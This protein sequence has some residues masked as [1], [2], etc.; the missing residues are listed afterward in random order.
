MKLFLIYVRDEDYY[1]LLP[2]KLSRKRSDD[3]V[4]VMAFPPLGIQTLAPAI[5]MQGHDVRMFDTCHPQMKE[6]DIAK[7]AKEE[8]PDIIALSFLST[9]SYP[10]CQSMA[11]FLKEDSPGIPIIIGGPFAT[12]N[13]IQILKDTPSID[14]VGIGEGEELIPDFLANIDDPGQVRGLVWRSDGEIIKNA[15]R[16]LLDDLDKYPYPDRQSLPIEYI[17]SMPLDVPAVLSLD[18]FCTMQT[19]RGCPFHC[20]YCDIPQIAQGKW[21][22]RSPEHV[23]GE[24]QELNDQGYRSIYLTDDH[25]LMKRK[26]IEAICNG[27]IDL[28]L[29]FHWGCE[30]RVDALAIDMLPL[31]KKANCN[32]LAFGVEAGTQKVLDRLNKNQTLEQIE[33]AIKEAK[34]IGIETVHGFFLIGSPD[35]TEEDIKESFRFAAKLNLDTF[36]FNRL[37]AYRGT[38]LWKEYV[39]RGIIDDELDWNKWFKCSDIDPT[40]LPSHVVNNARK[41]G[42]LILF[43]YLLRHRPIATFRLLRKFGRYMTTADIFKLLYSPFK[44]RTLTKLPDLPE[45]MLA[46]GLTEPIREA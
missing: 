24:M 44:K 30:G 8:A 18:R 16:P 15:A 13:A 17:E 21:R 43:G 33:N 10:A 25:F 37:C 35:E 1:N 32:F 11:K 29:G 3:R 22:Q 27:I 7:A 5:R 39:D 46:Q 26:R 23:L 2:D 19:T 31:M 20:I 34:R 45:K 38:P 9:T 28:K 4:E 41:K 36:G 6:A 40:I 42:Y 12:A 14:F